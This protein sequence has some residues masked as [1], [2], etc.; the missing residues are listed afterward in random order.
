MT[1]RPTS[2]FVYGPSLPLV[3]L[4]LYAFAAAAN[5]AFVWINV[6]PHSEPLDGGDPATL[7]WV[8]T[9]RLLTFEHAEE[10]RPRER[11]ADT[12]VSNLIAPDE[13]PASVERLLAFVR[14]PDLTQR[15]LAVQP[16]GTPAG[17]VVVPNCHGLAP[18][19]ARAEVGAIIDAHLRA[20]YSL[21]VGYPE[22]YEGHHH[23]A[24]PG[25][26]VFEHVFRIEGQG[27]QDWEAC[28]L[29][30]EKAPAGSGFPVGEGRALPE[31]PF[32]S[33]T[34]RRARAEHSRGMPRP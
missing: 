8:P 18:R 29:V 20:G 10:I 25:R 23:P 34:F 16:G 17:L 14:L 32:V 30:C 33:E 5:P 27:I 6:R 24:G 31:I 12:A 2:L 26:N 28:R 9:S 1:G 4:T 15:L 3:N 11:V 13:S 22:L 19:F 7:G 21:F